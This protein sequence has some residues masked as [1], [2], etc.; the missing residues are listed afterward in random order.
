MAFNVLYQLHWYRK[1]VKAMKLTAALILVTCLHVYGKSYTQESITLNEKNAKLTSVFK[2]ITKQT[3]VHFVHRDDWVQSANPV[4]ISVRNEDLKTVLQMLFQGQ[5]DLT[6]EVVGKMVT[7]KRKEEKNEVQYSSNN[8]NPAA[9]PIDIRGRV[10]NEKG[11][12]VEGVTVTVKGTKKATSTNANGEF[13]LSTVDPNAVLVFTSVNIE[14]FELEVSGRSEVLVNLKTKVAALGDVV[15]INTGYQTL[16]PNEVTGS[17]ARV[18]N[19]LFNRRVSTDFL[20]RLEGTASGLLMDGT[21]TFAMNNISI[22]GN[23]TIFANTQPLLIVD[24]FPYA[25]DLSSLNPNDIEDINILKDAAAASIWGAFSGNGVIVITT[26]RGR[27]NQPIKLSL[28]ASVTVGEKPDLFYDPNFLISSEMIG[29]EQFLFSRGYYNSDLNNTTSRPPVSL[30][31]EILAKQASG[32]ITQQQAEAQLN[33]LRNLDIRND[34]SK[35]FYRKS[36]DQQYAL[37][38]SGGTAKASY[39][40]SGGYNKDMSN[41]VRSQSE[42]I[43]FSA[44]SVFVPIKNLEIT[45]SIAHA[46]VINE[47]NGMTRVVSGGKVGTSPYTQLADADGNHLPIVQN[48]RLSFAQNPGVTGLLNWVHVPLDD[49]ALMDNQMHLYDDRLSAAVKYTIISGL[50]VALSY[51]YQKGI[52]QERIHNSVESFHTRDL[53]N[54]YSTV[55]NNVVT[56]RNIPLGGILNNITT[57]AT[58][59]AGRAQINYNAGFGDHTVTA[60]AGMDIYELKTD[61]HSSTTYGYDESTGTYAAVNFDSSYRLFPTGTGTILGAS[62]HSPWTYRYFRSLLGN[63]S[64]A[65]RNRYTFYLSGRLDQA[66]MF[67]VKANQRVNPLWSTG[68]RWDIDKENFYKSTW[69][70]ELKF[71]FSYGYQGNFSSTLSALTTATYSVGAFNN[72]P[73]ASIFTAGNPELGWE[74]I[75]I[76]NVGLDFSIGKKVLTGSIDFFRKNGVDMIGDKIIPSST[77]FTTF[78][79]NFSDMRANGIDLT[80]EGNVI[81]KEF[82]WSVRLLSSYVRDKITKNKGDNLRIT[83]RPV[84]AIYSHRWGGLD[85]NGD[86]LGYLNDTLTKNYNAILTAAS[87]DPTLR[88]YNGPAKPIFFGSILNSFSWKGISV[89]VLV[90]YKAG[91]YFR[92]SS[93]NYNTLFSTGAGHRD[94]TRRWQKPGDEATTSVPAMVYTNYPSF[95]QRNQFYQESSALVERGDHIRL[96]DISVSYTISRKRWQNAPFKQLQIYFY[97][98][99]LGILWKAND[100]GIDPNDRTGYPKPRALSFGVRSE[101]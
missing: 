86:P 66:N 28:N 91:Y 94:Y 47:N 24:G 10:V 87:A 25:G 16:K 88:V 59:N 84:N 20:S 68:L 2:K 96:Q 18:D 99:N 35:Y 63:I 15:V 53:I 56:R 58:T 80:L 76:I 39:Y 31:V 5:P 45:G 44:T 32:A 22:R 9:P 72:Y 13:S 41:V 37:N 4:T 29:V 70:S 90:T 71:R 54:R 93:I 55:T 83:G 14:T 40:L 8:N 17:V 95:T 81:K 42:R 79:G 75:G 26:K 82:A 74:K 50:S 27:L 52:N 57:N 78:R 46:Q 100:E 101:F 38:V 1:T 34:Y 11:D 85:A 67:G 7:V 30:A 43:S 61:G 69:L 77:G 51:R 92:R 19:E 6:F 36:I 64:Y 48:R 23:S 98:N 12:P 97:A 62:T 49:L 73:L 33:A 65:Y 21:S 89:S 60:L 3:G